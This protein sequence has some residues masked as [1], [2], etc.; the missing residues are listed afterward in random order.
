MKK[1]LPHF[2]AIAITLCLSFSVKGLMA[3][4]VNIPDPAFKA[5]LV[6]DPTINLN[7]DTNIQVAEA[8][9]YTGYIN[10]NDYGI[11]DMTGIEA[12]TVATGLDCGDNLINSLNISTCTAL[13]E[14]ICSS[15]QLT[16]LNLFSNTALTHVNCYGNNLTGLDVSN[17]FSLVDLDCSSNQ[18]TNLNVYGISSLSTLDCSFNQLTCLNLH[19]NTGLTSLTCYYNSLTSL[20]VKNGNNTNITTFYAVNNSAL[21]CIQVDNVAYSNANWTNIDV[22]SSFNTDCGQPTASFTSDAT[23][24]FGNIINFTDASTAATSWSWDFDDGSTSPSQNPSYTYLLPGTYIVTL[25]ASNCNGSDVFGATV[26][27]GK[28]VNGHVTYTGG[29]VTNGI[30]IIYPR[31]SFYTSFDTTQIQALD[32]SGNYNFTNIPNGDYL[33]KV[34]PDPVAY[35]TLIPTYFTDDLL[36]DSATVITQGCVSDYVADVVMAELGTS[37]G[38]P[39]LL[40]GV[41]IEGFGFGRA[42]G[43]PV[44][45]VDIKLGITSSTTIIGTTTTDAVGGFSFS[46]IGFGNYTVYV[47][48]PGLERDSSYTITVDAA[49]NQFLN[50]DYIVDSVAIYIIN[51]IGIENISDPNH[52]NIYPN[53]VKNNSTI[54][55][56]LNGTANVKLDVYNVLGVKVQ[57]LVNTQQEVGEYQFTFNP[58]NSQLKPGVYFISLTVDKKISTMRI[59]VME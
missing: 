9:A 34:F 31:Q 39:G 38:G 15:C 22:A 50:L 25:T 21:T 10:V 7:L 8:Q 57:S 45:G 23:Y 46:N 37:G 30:A 52:F 53:P 58:Q 19:A 33:V 27:Q 18:L 17:N 44:H 54:A 43:D 36:W 6:A 2:M 29:D 51:H 35:P 55:Y 20:N 16:S 24:C 11:T 26:I 42:P 14:L 3:Q 28:D 56:T 5:V 48:I 4:N 1:M 47:D 40:Q 41:V 13:T 49:N 59:I 32:A 12:F